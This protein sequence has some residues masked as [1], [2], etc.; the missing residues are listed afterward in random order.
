MEEA[1]LNDLGTTNT[2]LYAKMAKYK[3]GHVLPNMF[4]GPSEID[5]YSILSRFG[6][7]EIENLGPV[8]Q[9]VEL[10]FGDYDLTQGAAIVPPG[11]TDG[12]I[13]RLSLT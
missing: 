10:G 11:A 3:T 7:C 12:I 5:G 1:G 8:P 9:I 4:A 2:R 13:V 6:R